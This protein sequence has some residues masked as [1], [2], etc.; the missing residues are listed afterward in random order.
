MFSLNPSNVNFPAQLDFDG[1]FHYQ[2]I[3]DDKDYKRR[4]PYLAL[5]LIFLS[6]QFDV[7]QFPIYSIS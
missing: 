7:G 5:D 4:L 6:Y 2:I 3:F 1:N